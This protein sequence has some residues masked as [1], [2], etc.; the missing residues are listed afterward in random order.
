MSFCF[1]LFFI[2]CISR[3][4]RGHNI[5]IKN[6]IESMVLDS[7]KEYMWIHNRF[8]I[9]GLGIGYCCSVLMYE[10]LKSAQWFY[11]AFHVILCYVQICWVDCWRFA[12]EWLMLIFSPYLINDT[13]CVIFTLTLCKNGLSVCVMI[14][15][16]RTLTGKT[17]VN[18]VNLWH[19]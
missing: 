15:I 17:N 19:L 1:L 13:Y 18:T 5:S 12:V 11:C 2:I 6:V 9:L 16:F 10:E 4:K 7:E 8:K 3:I 14:N